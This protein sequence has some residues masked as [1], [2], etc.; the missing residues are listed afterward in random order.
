MLGSKESPGLRGPLGTAL[1]LEVVQ[2]STLGGRND[3][4]SLEFSRCEMGQ[5]LGEK[6]RSSPRGDPPVGLRKAASISHH[7]ERTRIRRVRRSDGRRPP[8]AP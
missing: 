4:P 7:M 6:A 2:V 1:S 3:L 8:P 5:S